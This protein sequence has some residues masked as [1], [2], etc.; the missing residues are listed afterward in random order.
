MAGLYNFKAVIKDYLDNR[1]KTDRQFA[2]S[3]KK[4]NKSLDECCNYILGEV[5]KKAK[6]G[7]IVL[8]REEVF[9]LAV[10]YY[11]EDDIKGLPQS[12]AACDIVSPIEKDKPQMMKL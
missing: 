9:G 6:T 11:D 3:Y 4:K 2:K 1:A 8:P 5:K 7:Q 12:S 10:H